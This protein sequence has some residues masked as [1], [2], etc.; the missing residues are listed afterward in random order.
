MDEIKNSVLI[1][2]C[3]KSLKQFSD[4]TFDCIVTDPPYGIK[5]MG[6]KWDK[7]LPSLDA[8]NECC[9]VL[10][11]G[12]LAFFM[13]APRMDVLWRMGEKLEKAGF[14]IDFSFIAW[15]QAQGFPKSKNMSNVSEKL[16]GAF[17]GNQLKPAIEVIIVCMKPLSEKSFT[18]QALKNGHGVTWLND[19]KI[20]TNENL[21][22]GAY[23]KNPIAREDAWSNLRKGDINVFKRGG[24]G[25][26]EQPEGRFPANLLVCDDALNDGIN[27]TTGTM[28][29]I[30]KHDYDNT[31]C[32][33]KIN[34]VRSIV[35]KSEGSFSRYFDLDAWWD[36]KI[37]ELPE[38]IQKTFPVIVVPKASTAEKNK[39][40][41]NKHQTVK[42]LKLMSYLITMGS[43]EGDL[44]LDPYCG[45]GTTLEAAN[46]LGRRFVGCELD[47]AHRE[48]IEARAYM[49]NVKN[50]DIVSNVNESSLDD[51]I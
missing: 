29:S 6:R 2:D 23:A 9:R 22:G 12:A 1:G 19:C 48:L 42:P 10:K 51:W 8:L 35:N 5:F 40:C 24:A 30:A 50:V 31:I 3:A 41:E 14:E 34:P 20:P 28:N 47:E 27:H 4:E 39:Y 44:I 45:S 43:R 18:E 36:K 11:S 13:C 37:S 38:N 15:A 25:E 46:L 17:A 16:N 33:G 21:N 49:Q 7:A 26:Y 32:Y